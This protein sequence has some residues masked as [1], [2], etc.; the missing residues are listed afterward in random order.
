MSSQ[1]PK[2]A[3]DVVAALCNFI[4]KSNNNNKSKDIPVTDRLGP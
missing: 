3:Q 4:I 1:R 2:S